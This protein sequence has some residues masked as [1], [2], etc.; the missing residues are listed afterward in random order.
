MKGCCSMA[1]QAVWDLPAKANRNNPEEWLPLWMHLQDTAF[2][3]EYL[4]TEWLP[5]SVK[6]E[7]APANDE[8]QML[9]IA[10]LLGALHDLGKSSPAFSSMLLQHIEGVESQLERD[11]LVISSPHAFK[12]RKE[13]AHP[14]AGEAVL[15]A[16]K[17][18]LCFAAMVGAHHGKPHAKRGKEWVREQLSP[19][20]SHYINYY[21]SH[22]L[23][24]ENQ[25]K[26]IRSWFIDRAFRMAG[27]SSLEEI[28][29]ISMPSQVLLT[30]LLIM[31]DWIASNE[32]YFPLI[33]VDERG[34]E[35]DYP[36]RIENGLSQLQLPPPWNPQCYSLSDMDFAE[37]FGFLPNAVQ[38]AV[39]EAVE[40]SRNPG[41]FVLE[42]QMGVGK[43]E[44]ALAGADLLASRKGSGGLFFG[45]PTQATSN[46]IFPRIAGWAA[47]EA[48]S[49]AVSLGIRLAH[50]AAEMN[51]EYRSIFH[52]TAS[53]DEDEEPLLVH[54]W[55]E[56]RKQAL[57][58]DF[59]IGTVDQLLLAALKQKHVMLR[60]LGLAG[61]VV[62]VDECHAYDAYMNQFLGRALAWLGTYGVPVILLSATLPYGRRAALIQAYQGVVHADQQSKE[63]WMVSKE[64]PLLTW[65]DGEKV[66]Q[67]KILI[68]GKPKR[69]QIERISDTDIPDILN[70]KLH[71]GG[72]AGI[73]VNTVKRAQQLAAGLKTSLSD[74]EVLLFHAG[75]TLE[76]KSAVEKE[77]LQR[78][79]KKPSAKRNHLVVV[80]TQV[81]EQSLDI[82]FDLLLT[83]LCPIDLLFQRIG[84]LHRHPRKRPAALEQPVCMVM[85]AG[86]DES[87]DEGAKAVYEEY[88]LM[89]TKKILPDSFVLPNDISPFVQNVYDESYQIN[90]EAEKNA[91]EKYEQHIAAKQN[92]ART[93]CVPLP[94][95]SAR[96][97]SRNTLEGW[98]DNTPQMNE[99]QAEAS[100]RDGSDSVEVILLRKKSAENIL[101][102]VWKGIRQFVWDEPLSNADALAVYQQKIR[103]PAQFG[104]PWMIQKVVQELEKK[105]KQWASQWLRNP[106]LTGELFLILEDEGSTELAGYQI[107]YDPLLGILYEKESGE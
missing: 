107:R 29:E 80:G 8:N 69:I 79:G 77:L 56:G 21:D 48:Q 92:A 55:F 82:D 67:R 74:E 10:I 97:K 33:S 62:I 98:L 101:T 26:E 65:T 52:G 37:Y 1:F 12:M 89:R 70:Q 38:K 72:C 90:P 19:Y 2:V 95:K 81:M 13:S 100:V 84:R 50:G 60:H 87:L 39:I 5:D 71:Q 6:R 64:Y 49:E 93:N 32:T 30:G 83:D 99:I 3:M 25:W 47:E 75:F 9:K 41:I 96:F 35:S 20:S 59:V 45:L 46:G 11:G 27:I 91:K 61:K 14:I 15:L 88:L 58:A 94:R 85:G 63:G 66:N 42:A 106:Y 68:E 24:M 76:Q 36:E 73:I 34:A 18:P 86:E 16:R 44:A 104:Q 78:L 17:F 103:L 43:T 102:D 105:T 57:L 7:I 51:G 22:N 40:T 53:I 28:P 23:K 54:P 4:F 31:A